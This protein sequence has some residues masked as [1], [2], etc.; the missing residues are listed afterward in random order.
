MAAGGDLEAILARH[1]SEPTRAQ[2]GEEVRRSLSGS[3]SASVFCQEGRTDTP[4]RTADLGPGDGAAA[5]EVDCPPGFIWLTVTADP[6]S[7]LRVSRIVLAK[8]SA[9]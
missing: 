5:V 1:A 9:S 4:P 6:A 2:I 8:T 3:G 7:R